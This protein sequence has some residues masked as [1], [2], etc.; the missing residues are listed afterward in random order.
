VD[1]EIEME[2]IDAILVILTFGTCKLPYFVPYRD[3]TFVQKVQ[4]EG[5][6]PDAR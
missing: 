2:I 1:E 5:V 4:G 3:V 6:P